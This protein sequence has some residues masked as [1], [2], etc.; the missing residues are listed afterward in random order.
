[1]PCRA[2]KVSESDLQ[3]ASDQIAQE[4]GS[5]RLEMRNR[6]RRDRYTHRIPKM[7]ETAAKI[8]LCR[9]EKQDELIRFLRYKTG[10]AAADLERW[11]GTLCSWFSAASKEQRADMA[12]ATKEPLWRRACAEVVKYCREKSL[13][14]WVSHLNVDRGISPATGLI[15]SE[16][17][18]R[19]MQGWSSKFE[20]QKR[21][22]RG[23][24]QFLRRWR[25]RWGVKLGKFETLDFEEP[26]ELLRKVS[27][28]H[29]LVFGGSG[30]LVCHGM[31]S[32][33]SREI[34]VTKTAAVIWTQFW[35]LAIG[36]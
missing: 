34:H 3:A 13:H 24:L 28:P 8:H 17:D 23:S 1:M 33:G 11:T 18:K 6:G 10:A 14:E 20:G 19:S 22:Y 31:A 5:L 35:P 25:C 29:P 32:R 4:L 27:A 21:K 36:L 9:F 15:L 2:V 12:S 16:L 30:F 7:V 26:K